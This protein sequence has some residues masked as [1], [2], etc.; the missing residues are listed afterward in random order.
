MKLRCGTHEPSSAS[1]SAVA[2]TVFPTPDGPAKSMRSGRSTS[3]SRSDLLR[4]ARATTLL[5]CACPS[6]FAL[7]APTC[8]H[9]PMTM[10]TVAHAMPHA[11]PKQVV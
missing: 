7:S 1:H 2:I 4:S 9:R 11:S 3:S 6:I 10:D 5:A 8:Q